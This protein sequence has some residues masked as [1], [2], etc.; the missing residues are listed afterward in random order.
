MLA[1]RVRE[2]RRYLMMAIHRCFPDKRVS[3]P[4]RYRGPSLQTC[5]IILALLVA[6]GMVLRGG[7]PPISARISCKS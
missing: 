6:G 3:R 5:R 2:G 7:I 1:H 4:A